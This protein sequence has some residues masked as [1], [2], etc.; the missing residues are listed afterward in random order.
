M[1]TMECLSI[2]YRH[3]DQFEWQDGIWA[4][5][6]EDRMIC[7]DLHYKY[8]ISKHLSSLNIM[9]KCY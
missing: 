5:V 3:V 9:L 7:F 8:E 4:G 1:M 6:D 2:G